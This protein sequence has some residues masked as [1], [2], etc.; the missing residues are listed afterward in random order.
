[1]KASQTDA[2]ILIDSRDFARLLR[3]SLRHVTRLDR[4][5]L[6]PRALNIGR[7]CKRW[8]KATVESW[9]SLGCPPRDKFEQLVLTSAAAGVPSREKWEAR[10]H[11]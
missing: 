6:C 5:A 10:T 7:R 2:S 8:K 4:D 11:A 3:V 1:M 9:L